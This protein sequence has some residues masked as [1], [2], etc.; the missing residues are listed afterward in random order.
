MGRRTAVAVA[1]ALLALF[2]LLTGCTSLDPDPSA[3]AGEQTRPAPVSTPGPDLYAAVVDRMVEG[4]TATFTFS[5]IGGGQT[6]SGTGQ[7][8]FQA[9]TYDA[10]VELTMPETGKVR[11]VLMP[12]VCYLAL[13]SAKGLPKDKPWLKVAPI[14]TSGFGK[15]LTPVV[16]QLRGSFDPSQALGLLQAARTVVEVGPSTVEGV[17][18]TRHHAVIGLRRATAMAEGPLEKQYQSMVDAGVKTLEYDIWLDTDGLPRRFS[19]DIPTAVGL[20]SMTGIYR[21]WGEKVSIES[22][23]AKEVFDA[24]DLD[25]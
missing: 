8:R 22:P 17:P 25:G 16:D 19:T 15:Q 1:G 21:D 20:Y 14:P 2:G 18:T 6:V 9:G 4:G 5:G 23:S 11:A 13:P 7:M 3:G 10:D 24:D 12:S